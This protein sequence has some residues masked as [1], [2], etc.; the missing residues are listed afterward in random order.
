LK[1]ERPV[2]SVARFRAKYRKVSVKGGAFSQKEYKARIRVH[3]KTLNKYMTQFGLY[4]RDYISYSV[5]NHSKCEKLL[6]GDRLLNLI[7]GFDRITINEVFLLFAHLDLKAEFSHYLI[8]KTHFSYSIFD[9]EISPHSGTPTTYKLSGYN[10]FAEFVY[11]ILSEY[12]VLHNY[13]WVSGLKTKSV[14]SIDRFL[15]GF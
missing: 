12:I 13:M 4:L 8:N 2:N 6:G 1:R 10:K 11:I 5:R 3:E 14:K 7:A 9:Q 15:K